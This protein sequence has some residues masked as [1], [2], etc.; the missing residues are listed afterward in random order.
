[1]QIKKVFM[2]V[3]ML[4]SL[5]VTPTAGTLITST[6][7]ATN[8]HIR[9]GE[10]INFSVNTSEP[11]SYLWNVS[12]LNYTTSFFNTSYTSRGSK[13]IKVTVNN[14]TSSESY[15]WQ[16]LVTRTMA[17]SSNPISPLKRWFQNLINALRGTS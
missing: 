16:I 1:M 4:L 17:T 2:I 3:V 9:Q 11:V 6:T 13:I 7:P 14:S 8:T 12:G 5:L 15:T 10:D